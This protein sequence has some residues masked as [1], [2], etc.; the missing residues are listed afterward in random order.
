MRSILPFLLFFSPLFCAMEKIEQVFG[1]VLQEQ[2][3]AK[4]L[5]QEKVAESCD[6]DR[7]YI[8]LLEKGKNQPSLRTVFALAAALSMTPMELVALVQEQLE[9][10]APEENPSE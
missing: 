2:R 5:T 9:Q 7:K 1:R 8:Y 6:L 4:K 3:T 10:N